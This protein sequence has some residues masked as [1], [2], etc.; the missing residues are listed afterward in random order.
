MSE[1]L[2]SKKYTAKIII[3]IGTV[4]SGKSSYARLLKAILGDGF[5]N[6]DGDL[7]DLTLQEVLQLGPERNDYTL[8]LI[9]KYLMLGFIPII[10]TGGGVLLSTLNRDQFYLREYVQKTLGIDII[11]TTVLI[12]DV[13]SE[14][15]VDP[16]DDIVEEYLKVYE[17]SDENITE[18]VQGRIERGE[19]EFD[20]AN[21]SRIHSLSRNNRSV[22]K[23][24]IGNTNFL[25]VFPKFIFG[26]LFS[27]SQ[28]FIEHCSSFINLPIERAIFTQKRLLV[29]VSDIEGN[30]I[31]SGH[32]TLVFNGS[33]FS[34]GIEEP[35][36]PR[37]IGGTLITI[38]SNTSKIVIAIPTEDFD[39]R[40]P[41]SHIT[42]ENKSHFNVLMKSVAQAICNRNK[43]IS[44]R[45]KENKSFIE[46]NLEKNMVRKSCLIELICIFNI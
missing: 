19:W 42:I 46:Y 33:G 12:S 16:A 45:Y 37:I 14:I 38:T 35:F 11:I 39:Q 31:S 4:G 9:V 30:F 7:L 20:I 8:S 40:E 2:T 22:A 18:V 23:I 10:S 15:Q 26:T 32:F 24:V 13:I 29:R 17:N 21:I 27:V 5:W 25:F 34:G 6:L 44:L 36:E 43:K 41:H 1:L 3:V 28:M